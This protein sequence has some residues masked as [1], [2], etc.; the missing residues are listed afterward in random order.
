MAVDV[1]AV[2]FRLGW[3]P[4]PIRGKVPFFKEWQHTNLSE[5]EFRKAYAPGDNVG[6]RTGW[7]IKDKI[8]LVALDP[9]QPGLIGFKPEVWIESGAMTHTTSVGPRVVFYT[10][11]ADVVSFTRK[12]AVRLSEL[13]DEERKLLNK[14][15]EGKTSIT[16]LEVLGEGRQFMAP[17]SRHPDTGEI[18]RWIVPPKPPEESLVIHSMDELREIM[19]KSVTRSR[20]VLEELFETSKIEAGHNT[21]LLNG[22][23]EKIKARLNY[24]GETV[25]YLLFHC[26]LHPPDQH[27][28]F[29]IHKAKFYCYDYHD[30]QAYSLKALAERLGI[31]LSDVDVGK[32]APAILNHISMIE[33]PNYAGR[34]VLVEAQV[35]ST[36]VAY[37][38]PKKV[39]ASIKDGS[40]SLKED[41]KELPPHSPLYI[42][43]VGI[44]D[45]VKYR[46]LKSLFGNPST[47]SISEESQRTVYWVRVRPPVFTLEKRGERIIDEKGYEYKAFDVYAVSDK[48]ISFEPSALIRLV[49]IPLGSPKTQR[50]VLLA[51]NVEFVEAV[52]SFDKDKLLKLKRKLDSLGGVKA[53]VQW[54]LKNFERFSGIVGRRNLALAGL[55]A[56]FS[57]TWVYLDGD[58]QRGWVIVLFI[59]DTTTGKS[60]TVLK[61][62][63]LLKAG[64]FI[65]AETASQVGLTGTAV[66]V[67]KEGWITEWG[68]LV[69]ADRKLLAIDGYHKLSPSASAG[70]AEAERQGVVTIGKAAKNS[71]YAR[72]RQI[73]M[74]NPVDR[75]AG[76]FETRTLNSFLYPCQA[77][78]TILDKTSIARL[79]LAVF[80]AGEDVKA[81]DVNVRF[82]EKPDD[83]IWL[84]GEA[85]RWCWSETAKVEFAEEAV[86]EILKN[87]TSLYNTFHTPS[88]PI[89]SMDM[90]WKLA[91][92]SAAL[93]ALTLSTEDFAKIKVTGE[94][95]REVIEFLTD[96]YSKAGLNTLAQEERY[97]VYTSEEVEAFISKTAEQS[98]IDRETLE[99]ILRF[100][101]H[102]GRFTRDQLRAEFNLSENNQLRPLL[103]SL[104]NDNLIRAG[105]GFYPTP[106]L[107]QLYKTLS[108]SSLSSLSRPEKNPQ[109][110]SK[111][112]GGQEKVAPFLST[113]DKLDKLDRKGGVSFDWNGHVIGPYTPDIAYEKTVASIRAFQKEFGSL[114]AND[115]IRIL[116]HYWR[117]ESHLKVAEKLLSDDVIPKPCYVAYRLKVEWEEDL[118]REEIISRMR[119]LGFSEA[120]SKQLFE[121]L[122]GFELFW[123]DKDGK[124][125]WGWVSLDE[126]GE[127]R[128]W[129]L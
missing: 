99:N 101:V 28:S 31:N 107:I 94:H 57:P 41:V 85:L 111:N 65:T 87:A 98:G 53:K 92:L 1:L 40:G 128:Y 86:D 97:E 78:P 90:K 33:D 115:L 117:E 11:S 26:P 91:R 96:E 84:L 110:N 93:A 10:D 47:V 9:D 4:I 15:A 44:N 119:R 34:P 38:V 29:V 59:G 36:S 3:R 82:E 12:V 13:S 37:L 73:K 123:Y 55:L 32:G 129:R 116:S 74:A 88:V 62:I 54:I 35:G 27:P 70:T 66:Q 14:K 61:L 124:T 48:P 39:K 18:L 76:R 83:D 64:L 127:R 118:T 120:E 126:K 100:I 95:V 43:F 52:Q 6:L 104:R 75:E 24:A 79:D 56:F 60:E 105:R 108:S 103:A 45:D 2:Y 71:A 7:L 49:A 25:N 77:I 8:G 67:E 58:I 114:K 125:L 51:S 16:I 17:P 113:V 89:V 102:R 122:A 112:S 80:A 121:E 5:E 68:F 23:I 42:K 46:R 109:S 19:E 22:W 20:W 30:D 21:E 69:L 72:T 50:I 106:K 63:G 81:E